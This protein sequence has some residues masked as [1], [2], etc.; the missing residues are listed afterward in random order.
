MKKYK[1]I[2]LFFV[3]TSGI[4]SS[5]SAQKEG[6]IW[7]FG[8]GNGVN[9]NQTCDIIDLSSSIQGTEGVVSLSSPDGELLFYTNGGRNAGSFNEG[10]IWNKDHDILYDMGT[11]EGG[12]SSSRQ[13]SIAVPKVGSPGS[14]Y[15]FTMDESEAVFL[16]GFRGLS[17]FE[18]DMNLNGGL[19]G[20]VNY[21]AS[22]NTGGQIPGAFSVEGLG[23]V[24]KPDGS[25]Y[26]IVVNDLLAGPDNSIAYYLA[27][28]N[29][30][31]F[32]HAQPSPE[33]GNP[34]GAGLNGSP[35]KF[36]PNGEYV[37]FSN[38]AVRFDPT[39]GMYTDYLVNV[40]GFTPV[41]TVT[42]VSFSPDSR[43]Y[44]AAGDS[45][46]WRFDLTAA[47]VPA[48]ATLI[49]QSTTSFF[50]DLQVAPDGNIYLR[51]FDTNNQDQSIFSAILC[52]N[53]DSP[54]FRE[55]IYSFPGGGFNQRGLPNF[56]DHYFASDLLE[57][58]LEIC[59]DASALAI[60]PGEDVT[61][62][63]NHYLADSFSWSNGETSSSITITEPGTYSVTI[64]DGC[65]NTGTAEIEI[66]SNAGGILDLTIDGPTVICNSETIT[67]SAQSPI[68]TSYEWSNGSTSD[69]IEVTMSGIYSV[70]VSE[71]ICG[72]TTSL[73]IE[74]TESGNIDYDFSVDGDIGCVGEVT[75]AVNI[76]TGSADILWSTGESTEQITV[77]QVGTYSVTLSNVCDSQVENFEVAIS[78]DL[79]E[80]PNA[81]TPDGD[82]LNDLFL[83]VWGCSDVANYRMSV[84]NR[85]GQKVFETNDP[86]LGWNGTFKNKPAVSDVFVYQLT[87]E[88]GNGEFIQQS[89][90]VT[91][92]R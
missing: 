52:P 37:A 10:K 46:I 80:M 25:G 86:F 72:S 91:L 56:L 36:S 42:G 45:Q 59:L 61:L 14:Y 34:N 43:Y 48:S 73:E 65:C 66:G 8:A 35:I 22:I 84:Y 83:P 9:F 57:R 4:I 40:G 27:D 50:G 69:Q 32:S 16:G 38:V 67:L 49:T 21:E 7:Y 12:G 1:I 44:F 85:W 39:T 62:S 31:N 58:D 24:A 51:Q 26:W 2:F 18:I 3:L 81:F 82:G 75:A 87:L 29:G 15:L 77:N 33:F 17:Y 13:S 41:T 90:D 76:N 70:T 23:A 5:V 54:C 60:C 55:G 47:D 63:A 53:T 19:G 74:V 28:Q 89:G 64:S 92:I 6:N 88:I 79:F 71:D 20:V 30:V 11:T 78:D 68:A